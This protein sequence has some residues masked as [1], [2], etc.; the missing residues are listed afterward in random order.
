MARLATEI[1]II[2][3]R[4]PGPPYGEHGGDREGGD[5]A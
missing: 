2:S 4:T 5:I 1:R 3:E